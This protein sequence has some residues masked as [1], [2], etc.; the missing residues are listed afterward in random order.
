MYEKFFIFTA[1]IC[2]D[3]LDKVKFAIFKRYKYSERR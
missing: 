3:I 1:Y 2:V